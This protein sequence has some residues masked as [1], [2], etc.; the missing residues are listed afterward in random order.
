MEIKLTETRNLLDTFLF[1]V[2][3]DSDD[4]AK[5][6]AEV[7]LDSSEYLSVLMLPLC[8]GNDEDDVLY[9]AIADDHKEYC[10]DAN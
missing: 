1:D 10:G 2:E 8:Y 9:Y 7:S 5:D 4:N 3:L 6:I